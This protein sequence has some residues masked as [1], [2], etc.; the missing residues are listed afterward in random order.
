M[1]DHNPGGL[2]MTSK[3]ELFLELTGVLEKP[4]VKQF[5]ERYLQNDSQGNTVSTVELGIKNA[6][7]SIHDGLLLSMVIA[8][9][10]DIKFEGTP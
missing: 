8:M 3:K 6:Q 5:Y 9:Q 2:A 1:G 4:D 7:I 10:W